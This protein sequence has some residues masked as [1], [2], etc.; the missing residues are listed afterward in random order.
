MAPS[1][2]GMTS[3]PFQRWRLGFHA[4]WNARRPSARGHNAKG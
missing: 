2:M 3:A 4:A 1:W